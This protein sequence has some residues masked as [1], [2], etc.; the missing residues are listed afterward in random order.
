MRFTEMPP[1]RRGS[2]TISFDLVPFFGYSSPRKAL[3]GRFRDCP[4]YSNASI[5]PPS[6]LLLFHEPV[7]RLPLSLGPCH[8][9]DPL[10]SGSTPPVPYSQSESLVGFFLPRTVLPLT[11]CGRKGLQTWAA[12]IRHYDLHLLELTLVSATGPSASP[13]RPV[14]GRDLDGCLE[15]RTLHIFLDLN[16]SPSFVF[17]IVPPLEVPL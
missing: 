16:G 17:E 6:F 4:R 1:Q 15:F 2:S 11:G 10:M 3:T 13:I 12:G 14:L 9:S 7:G 5:E 8:G